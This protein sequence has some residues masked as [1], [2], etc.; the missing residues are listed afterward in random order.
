MSEKLSDF[1]TTKNVLEY[2][3]N[4]ITWDDNSIKTI[5]S[6][7]SKL[8]NNKELE[9]EYLRNATSCE[10]EK[11]TSEN[12]KLKEENETYRNGFI[13][14]NDENKILK[15][16]LDIVYLIF[17]DKHCNSKCADF[18]LTLR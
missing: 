18:N 11:L 3:L 6:I 2:L 7:I 16:Q 14:L 13:S 1:E 4:N 5:E 12:H 15:S 10:I 9:I 17:G 8:Q